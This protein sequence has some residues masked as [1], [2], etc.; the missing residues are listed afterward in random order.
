MASRKTVAV[1]AHEPRPFTWRRVGSTFWQRNGISV[2]IARA[3]EHLSEAILALPQAKG[4]VGLY[5]FL[6]DVGSIAA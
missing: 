5:G 2:R 4:G 1:M 6:G 3:R